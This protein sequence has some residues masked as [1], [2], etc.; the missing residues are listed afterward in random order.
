MDSMP[1]QACLEGFCSQKQPFRLEDATGQAVDVE[2]VAVWSGV[3]MS[4]DY[5]CYSLSIRLP[6]GANANQ[7]TYRLSHPTDDQSWNLLFT[8]SQPD[9]NGQARM[10][11]VFHRKRI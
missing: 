1:S 3:A 6:H 10:H 7:G 8:P 5:T 11:A 4:Q 9:V 2:L